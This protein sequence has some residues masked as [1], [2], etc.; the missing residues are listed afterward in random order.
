VGGRNSANT[1][2]LLATAQSLGLPSWLV[3]G[4]EE[5]PPE[6]FAYSR[7]GVTAGASTPDEAIAEV[8][9][10]LLSGPRSRDAS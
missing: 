6:V 5:L 4:P 3:E 1:T 7:V 10:A 8:E 9:A 2:R